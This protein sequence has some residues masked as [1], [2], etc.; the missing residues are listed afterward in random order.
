MLKINFEMI[1]QILQMPDPLTKRPI[2]SFVKQQDLTEEGK[3]TLLLEY[4]SSAKLPEQT[5]AAIR[6]CKTQIEQLPGIQSANII[7]T[8]K[9]GPAAKIKNRLP[10]IDKIIVVASGKGG[11]GK[12]TIAANLAIALMNIG[13]KV[14]LLDADIFGP[15]APIIFGLANK[16]A[17][18]SDNKFDPYKVCGIKMMSMGLLVDQDTAAIWRGP[19]ATKALYKLLEGTNWGALDYL[20]IDTPPGTSDIH[21]SLA[22]NY[23]ID[24]AIIVSTPQ[25]LAIADAVKAINMFNKMGI[26]I[27]GI[28]ENMS[29]LENL[30]GTKTSVFGSDSLANKQPDL[31]LL[32]QIPITSILSNNDNKPITYTHYAHPITRLFSEIAQKM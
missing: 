28:I 4:P 14:G 20:V 21:L 1:A 7:I 3:L 2:L 19:M 23:H 18:M 30:D 5:D 26:P 29:Y 25:A 6:S 8:N 16:K 12:S 15:S 11:V 13:K 31:P 17:T 22:E 24:N 27:A 10:G 9:P 32:A